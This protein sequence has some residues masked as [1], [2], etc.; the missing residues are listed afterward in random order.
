[1]LGSH[2]QR[3]KPYP[4]TEAF[5]IPFIIKWGDNL[6]HR[7]E[8]L[9][10]SVPDVM[11]TLLALGGLEDQIPETVQ[12]TN[13]AEIIKD[14]NK[15]KVHKPD[16]VLYMDNKSRGIYT[17]DYTFIVQSEDRRSFSVAYYY[18]NKNDPYQLHKIMGDEMDRMLVEKFMVE[19]VKQ[20]KAIGDQWAELDWSGIN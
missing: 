11:P 20:L 17:G 8:D 14:P 10:L 15:S 1:M 5:N 19:L 9:I 6:K 4:E 18:D 3:G 7:V 13:Y 12:G 2:G 16:Q